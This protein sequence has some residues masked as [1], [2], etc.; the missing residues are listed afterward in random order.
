VSPERLPAR[1]RVLV[2]DDEPMARSTLVGLLEG[3]G[4]MDLCGEC[5]NGDEALVAIREERPD[6]LFLDVEMPGMTGL[7]LLARLSPGERPAVVFTTAYGEYALD[8][9]E[10]EAIDYLKKPFDDERFEEAVRRVRERLAGRL[11]PPDAAGA[12][13]EAIADRIVIHREGRIDVV[14]LASLEWVEAADQYVRL[15]TDHGEQLMRESMGQLERRLDKRRFLR[16]HRS[17]IVALDRVRRLESR[18][19]GVGRLLLAG[20][21][22]VPVSRSRFPLVRRTLG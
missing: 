18:G 17:A 7:E 19:G 1:L 14:E 5:A 6:L 9:F 15:H 3:L 22:W 8:A 21:A 10:V 16:V 12:A 13:T 11:F 2:V 4:D 20:G